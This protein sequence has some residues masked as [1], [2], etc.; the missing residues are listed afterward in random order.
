MSLGKLYGVSLGPG[1]ADLMT[2]R[3]LDCLKTVDCIAIPRKDEKTPSVAW[4]TAKDIVGEVKGQERLFLNFPMT[5]NPEIIKPAWDIAFKEIGERLMAGQDVAFITVGDAFIYSTFIYLYNHAQKIWPEVEI[6]VIPGVSSISAVPAVAGI[7]VADGQQRIAVIPAS[8]NV[9]DL[10]TVFKMFDTVILMK[11][12]GVM[13][14][15][16]EVLEAEGLI[17][18]AVY[19]AKATMDGEKIVRDLRTIKEKRCIYFS[20]VVVSRNDRAGIL[21]GN[22]TRLLSEAGV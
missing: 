11:I 12:S 6:E 9:E 5:K 22:E 15:I 2:I 3:A 18:H 1:A 21:D 20:M 17:D 10:R 13:D 19:V 4:A 7:P 8:Y 14:K 16:V